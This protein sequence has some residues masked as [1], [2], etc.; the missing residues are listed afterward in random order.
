MNRYTRRSVLCGT[1][2]A[3][4]SF[5]GC[6]ESNS[7]PGFKQSSVNGRKLIVEFEESLQPESVSV[8]D[9]E[10]EGFAETKVSTGVTQVSFEI[11]IP[12][13]PGEYR[14]IAVDSAGDELADTSQEIRPELEIVDVGIGANHIDEMP[15]ELHYPERQ[16]IVSIINRGTGPDAITNLDILDKFP[17]PT[18][19]DNG[20]NIFDEETGLAE[21]EQKTI[22]AEAKG[23]IFSSNVPFADYENYCEAEANRVTAG[24]EVDAKILGDSLKKDVE[25]EY[26][27]SAEENPCEPTIKSN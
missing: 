12:Y 13:S 17:N 6:S 19:S 9:P 7:D 14:I 20:S 5:A 8:I 27:A 22:P 4:T 10:G 25:L 1:V 3:A 16:I 2:G 26:S 23:L 15:E 21:A 18:T 24:I 11:G